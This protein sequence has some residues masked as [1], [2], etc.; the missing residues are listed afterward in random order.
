M[1]PTIIC[2]V[3]PSGCGKTTMAQF[4]E[5]ELGV[6]TI[7]SCTTR[8]IREGEK[9]GREHF[10][11]TDDEVPSRDEMLAY[12]R[13]GGFQYYAK[14][15]DVPANGAVTYVIDEKGLMM[16][17][18]EFSDRYNIQAIL[19]KR[20]NELIAQ[21]IDK[22]RAQRDKCRIKIDEQT[23]DA[24]ITNNGSLLEFLETA[25]RTIKMML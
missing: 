24:V 1:K 12:T 6:K 8:P 21:G 23:Y 2:I 4:I 16:L 13:F 20:D 11:V 9:D 7:V 10:F 14:H 15:S 18:E 5:K 22:E 17:M 3:G 25:K 19:I